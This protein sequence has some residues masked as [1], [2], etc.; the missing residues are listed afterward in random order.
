MTASPLHALAAGWEALR[1]A[2]RG[3][4]A[5]VLAGFLLLLTML[6]LGR[7]APDSGGLLAPLTV[8]S[9]VLSRERPGLDFFTIYEAGHAVLQGRDPYAVAPG[10]EAPARAP[11]FTLFRY[12]PVTAVWLGVPLNV[13]PPWPAFYAWLV[14][15]VALVAANFLLCVGR[16][17]RFLPLQALIWFAWFPLIAEFHMGQFTLLMA[18]ALLW[19]V[20]AFLSGR[21]GSGIAAWA[22]AVLLKVYPVA[23][24]PLLARWGAWKAVALA[25]VLIAASSAA[26]PLILPSNVAEGFGRTN[27]EG[28]FVLGIRK[29]YAGAMGM[30]ELTNAAFWK[31]S[32]R[33]FGDDLPASLQ[34][35]PPLADPVWILNALLVGCFGLVCFWALR[36]G[37]GAQNLPA[38]GIFWLIWFYAYVDCWEHHYVLVQALLGLL[39]ARGAMDWRVALA[40]WAGAGGPSLWWFWQRSG[41][42]GNALTESVGML[43][44]LQR[45]AGL[46]VLTIWLVREAAQAP[47]EEA[48]ELPL[49]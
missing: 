16:A 15:L 6:P 1:R 29:P 7:L 47:R 41:Y 31:L 22:V 10:M 5:A 48:Q 42:A 24:A 25:L 11:Y 30:Q 18:T 34:S 2:P 13:L 3:Q 38:L 4:Q 17:P 21:R 28:R 39:V 35:L 36:R 49:P 27:V 44:F 26:V 9:G 12:L 19:G 14:F 32:G 8:D 20:D 46:L 43:Y 40:V 33:S 37:W 23:M 45:P